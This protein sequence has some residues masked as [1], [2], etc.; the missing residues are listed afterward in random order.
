MAD[1]ERTKADL[2]ALYADN[3]SGDISPQDLRDLV[4]TMDR[5]VGFMVVSTPA[6]TTIGV[7]G[8]YYLAAG[9]TTLYV[10]RDFTMPQ[11]NRL[12]YTGTPKILALV[13]LSLTLSVSGTGNKTLAIT[14]Y[15]GGGEVSAKYRCR[16]TL[17]GATCRSYTIMA[18]VSMTTNDYLE[19]WITNETDTIRPQMELAQMVVLGLFQ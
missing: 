19:I 12:T 18:L 7:A 9:T 13:A 10:S 11:N 16:S 2:L 14:L 3:T 5:P 1:T 17:T 6:T 15:K 8:T 4:E